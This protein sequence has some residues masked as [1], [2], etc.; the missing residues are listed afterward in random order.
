MDISIPKEKIKRVSVET[1]LKGN[2]PVSKNIEGTR[3][4]I[5]LMKSSSGNIRFFS[6]S[7]R[8]IL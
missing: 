2:Y 4:R 3:T 1:K 7:R 5:R 8:S 6:R